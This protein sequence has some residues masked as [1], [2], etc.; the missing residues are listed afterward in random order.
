M[1]T[2]FLGLHD[3]NVD[4]AFMR[5]ADLCCCLSKDEDVPLGGG[6]VYLH[7]T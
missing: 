1:W 2:C 4:V 5:N 6:T 3:M 7:H